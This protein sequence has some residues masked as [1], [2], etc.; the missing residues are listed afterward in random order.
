MQSSIERVEEQKSKEEERHLEFVRSYQGWLND[1]YIDSY[2]TS[3]MHT[4]FG[5]K[6]GKSSRPKSTKR[7][8]D[9]AVVQNYEWKKK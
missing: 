6:K 4:S 1:N 3:R 7:V 2:Q 8:P 9:I 5:M